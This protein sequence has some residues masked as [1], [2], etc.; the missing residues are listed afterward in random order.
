MN[1]NYFATSLCIVSRARARNK[2]SEIARARER[3]KKS[4]LPLSINK[5]RLDFEGNNI[6]II[7]PPGYNRFDFPRIIIGIGRGTKRI[8]LLF[9]V[10]DGD[11]SDNN[12]A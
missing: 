8:A 7:E 2:E 9:T 3:N 4:D 5:Q 10:A 6:G 11:T 1:A 12:G